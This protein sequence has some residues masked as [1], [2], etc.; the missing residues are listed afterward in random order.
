MKDCIFCKIVAGEIPADRI[1]E[2]DMIL[3]FLDIAPINKGHALVVPRGHHHSICSVPSDIRAR[4]MERAPEIA[5]AIMRATGADGFNFMLSN[6]TCAGQ[7]VPHAHL[8]IIPRSPADGVV[9]PARSV[10]YENADEKH[11]M[12]AKIRE[13]L[14]V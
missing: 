5:I 8:H 9:L 14:A 10:P 6:G 4:M 3:V 11:E 2:D 7:I 1:Y 12:L 13:R